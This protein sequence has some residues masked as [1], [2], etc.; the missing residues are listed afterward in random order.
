MSRDLDYVL[1]YMTKYVKD[2][3]MY[4]SEPMLNHK[5]IEIVLKHIYEIEQE[6]KQLKEENAKLKLKPLEG[7][8]AQVDDDMLLRS[9]GTMQ[10]EIDNYKCILTELEEYLKGKYN[11]KET[12]NIKLSDRAEQDEYIAKLET[13]NQYK[14][15]LGQI[16]TVQETLDKIQ[17]LKEKYK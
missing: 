3:Y 1:N 14:L 11:S 4:D 2:Q 7:I 13:E 15:D 6:N 12:I 16:F 17:E 8:F 10:Q 5:D 9:C